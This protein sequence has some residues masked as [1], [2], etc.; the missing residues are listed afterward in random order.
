M[1]NKIVCPKCF[2]HSYYLYGKNHHG[3]QK[4]QCKSCKSQFTLA[5]FKHRINKPNK[6]PRCP[7]CGK[8][9]F[10]H[11]DYDFYSYF[12][13]CDKLCNHHFSIIKKS[14]FS[15]L[16][17]QEVLKYSINLK[18]LRTH[19]SIIIDA[20]YLFFICSSSTRAISLYLFDRKNISISHVAIFKWT[21]GFASIFKSIMEKHLP[22]DLNLS[23]EWHID[24]TV[25]KINGVRYYIWTII[26]SETR[27]VI[28]F[29][30]TTSRDSSAAF[31]ILT[32]AKS[33]FGAPNAIVSDRLPSYIE[34]VKTVFD[35][36]KHVKVQSWFD[37]ITNNLIESFFRRLKHKYK[38]THG[39]KSADSVQCFL[40]SFFYF[41][42]YIIP[43]KALNN[44]TPARVAGAK[45][46]ELS[47][48]NLLLF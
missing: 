5:S 15:A 46:S 36:S 28:D 34:P 27:F 1:S 32:K 43:H 4:Y 13:C 14:N 20:L 10:L 41:Y 19:L 30:L 48:S 2:H 26:D 21:R 33:K 42:N 3:D 23:D 24:E 16:L 39:L 38:T 37:D 17:H 9:S 45:Y 29:Y 47:R 18:R 8:S 11:H 22:I 44:D 7:K 6:Y 35:T 25:I 40:T 31:H 12:T